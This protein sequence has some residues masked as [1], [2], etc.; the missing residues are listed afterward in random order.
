[1]NNKLPPAEILCGDCVKCLPFAWTGASS[2]IIHCGWWRTMRHDF[3]H[4]KTKIYVKV[5]SPLRYVPSVTK[6]LTVTGWTGIGV[7]GEKWLEYTNTASRI[8]VIIIDSMVME[9]DIFS[10]I[11][12]IHT[13]QNK[14]LLP[15]DCPLRY[16]EFV[17]NSRQYIRAPS[18]YKDR[19]SQVWGFPC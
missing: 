12:A 15:G 9:S 1:M 16:R 2:S 14:C 13:R 7:H 3:F 19:L 6:M 4:V 5:S 11:N 17:T 8:F 18:Q 10:V